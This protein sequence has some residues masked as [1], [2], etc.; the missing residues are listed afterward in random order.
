MAGWTCPVVSNRRGSG[1]DHYHRGQGGC[2]ETL[3]DVGDRAACGGGVAH[4]RDP[5][6]G[7]LSTLTCRLFTFGGGVVVQ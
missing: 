2:C 6:A 7:S 1:H 3:A 5:F 4:L